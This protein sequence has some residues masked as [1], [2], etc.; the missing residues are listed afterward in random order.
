MCVF[1][2]ILGWWFILVCLDAVSKAQGCFGLCLINLPLFRK[3]KIKRVIQYLEILALTSRHTNFD[4]LYTRNHINLK[5]W[6]QAI[7]TPTGARCMGIIYF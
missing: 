1:F 7:V 3:I 6:T 2:G 4:F 5:R